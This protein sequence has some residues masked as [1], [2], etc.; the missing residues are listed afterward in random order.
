[1]DERFDDISPG[2]WEIGGDIVE[3]SPKQKSPFDDQGASILASNGQYVVEG[4]SQDEQ[5][6]AV[7]VLRMPDAIAIA[8]LPDIIAERDALRAEVERLR[9]TTRCAWCGAE[10]QGISPEH[11]GELALEHLLVCPDHPLRKLESLIAELTAENERLRLVLAWY[12]NEDNWEPIIE[13]RRGFIGYGPSNVAT[14]Y[15][16]ERPSAAAADYGD[17]ARAALAGEGE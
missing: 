4:G 9:T 1:M 2:P 16:V 6:G 17:R 5:G 13:H 12:A 7:G 14:D 11:R 8:A 10:V 15:D 3:W